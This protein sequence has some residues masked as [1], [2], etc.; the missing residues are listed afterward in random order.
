MLF[1]DSPGVEGLAFWEF[2]FFDSK[3]KN[4]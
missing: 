1:L 2:E 4:Q 3:K